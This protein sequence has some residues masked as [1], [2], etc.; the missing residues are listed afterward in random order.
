MPPLSLRQRVFKAGSWTLVGH[1]GSQALRFASNLVLTR[2][3]FPEAFGLMALMYSILTG[4]NMLTDLGI[5]QSIVTSARG[6]D[7]AYANT[8]WTMQV[9]KGVLVALAMVAIAGPAAAHFEQPQMAQLMWGIGLIALVT[10]FSSTNVAIATR[11]VDLA[12]LTQIELGTQALGIVATVL[13]AWRWP[14]VWSLVWGNLVTSLARV[15]ASQLLLPG[16]RNRFAWDRS[17]AR[18]IFSFGGWIMLSSSITFLLGEGNRLLSGS[19]VDIRLIGFMGLASAL[20]MIAWTAIQQLSSRVLFPA[21]AEVARSGDRERLSQVVEKSRFMQVLPSWCISVLLCFGGGALIDLLYDARYADAG[22]VLRIQSTGLMVGILS[23][24]Y[25]GVLWSIGKVRM[26]TLL[27]GIQALLL[28]CGMLAG[29]HIGGP[30]G[31]L[32]GSATA[33]W[34]M[35]P[36]S[37]IVFAREGLWHPRLDLPFIAASIAVTVLMALT[38]DWSPVHAWQPK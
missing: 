3:L 23:A 13:F 34:L 8:A 17:A 28:W 36:V 7:P 21:Y 15:V 37:A 14:S 6:A 10:S 1:V 12:R 27:L 18:G 29:F 32:V 11:N 5:N 9:A 30:V 22:V 19:L 2:L 38:T 20:N 26:N 31:V 16:P 25:A 24:S 4:I 35:Y 33:A